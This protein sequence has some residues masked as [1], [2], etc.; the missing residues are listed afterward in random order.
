MNSDSVS[1]GTKSQRRPVH[2]LGTAVGTDDVLNLIG[3]RILK[4]QAAHTKPHPVVIFGTESIHH[5]NGL[6]FQL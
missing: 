1:L 6:A 3:V 2:S 4:T 5:G